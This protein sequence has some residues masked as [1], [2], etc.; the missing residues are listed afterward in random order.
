MSRRIISIASS[1]IAALAI[2][3][4]GS[5]APAP[6]AAYPRNPESLRAES[7]ASSSE[8]F[9][10]SDSSA[11]EPPND[12]Q[13]VADE[14]PAPETEART[15]TEPTHDAAEVLTERGVVFMIDYVK[16]ESYKQAAATCEELT[17]KKGE[18]GASEDNE[19]LQACLHWAR[20]QFSAD[21]IRFTTDEHG[22]LW[23]AIYKRRGDELSEA[24]SSPVEFVEVAAHRVVMD[25]KGPERGKRSLMTDR[26]RFTIAVPDEYTL[27][28]TDPRFGRL[29]YEAKIGLVGR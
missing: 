15:E 13:E 19:K 14:A 23:W 29:V 17:S 1:A 4:C 7:K 21:A 10:S 24:H 9:D 6:Q 26:R 11:T 8:A 5:S 27:E 20:D 25:V 16:T 28:L 3:A 12:Q 2:S 22:Q 18:D